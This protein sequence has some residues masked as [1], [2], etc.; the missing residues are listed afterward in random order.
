MRKWLCL[1]GTLFVLGCSDGDSAAGI[2][3][4]VQHCGGEEIAPELSTRVSRYSVGIPSNDV[5]VLQLCDPDRGC[6]AVASYK[7]STAPVAELKKD[8]LTFKIPGARDLKILKGTTWIG[9]REMPL[10]VIALQSNKDVPAVN[11]VRGCRTDWELRPYP[12]PAP[13]A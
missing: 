13:R 12:E 6:S 7:N 5:Y 9:D 8:V 1:V 10:A 3:A 2:A 4:T 11:A